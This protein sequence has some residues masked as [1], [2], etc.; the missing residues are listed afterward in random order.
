MPTDINTGTPVKFENGSRIIIWNT[1]AT[2]DYSVLWIVE[3]T[4]RMRSLPK[5]RIVLRDR[6]VFPGGILPGN[7]R[8]SELTF[9]VLALKLGMTGTNDLMKLMKPAAVNGVIPTFKVDVEI[10]DYY[11]AATGTRWS[12]LK[13]FMDEGH[14]YSFQEGAQADRISCRLMNLGEVVPVTF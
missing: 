5:E 7:E 11:G 10:V 12:F 9:D 2:T 6:S 4:G 13:S 14:D 8:M 3:G 1:G